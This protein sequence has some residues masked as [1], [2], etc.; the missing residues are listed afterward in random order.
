MRPLFFFHRSQGFT[1]FELLVVMSILAVVSTMGFVGFIR[2]SNQ[3]NDLISALTLEKGLSACFTELRQDFQNLLPADCCDTGLQGLQASLEDSRRYWRVIFEDDSISFPVSIFNPLKEEQE[4]FLVRY[5]IVRN[6]EQSRLVRFTSPL[7][8]ENA[9]A[10]QTFAQDNVLAMRILYS[11][12][13][14][15]RDQWNRREMPLAVR[16]SLSCMDP[17]NPTRHISRVV[18]F[19]INVQ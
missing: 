11:D 18:A 1:L 14:R 9:E 4:R 3:W 2:T 6:G 19:K 8:I 17:R 15:W 16:I 10:V 7:D 5:R 12:G 13:D